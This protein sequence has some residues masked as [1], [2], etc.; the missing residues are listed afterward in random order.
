MTGGGRQGI[1][2]TR[3]SLLN[4]L[5]RSH[6][7]YLFAEV[8]ASCVRHVARVLRHGPSADRNSEA[9][10]LFSEVMAKLVGAMSGADDAV[11]DYVGRDV[12]EPWTSHDDPKRDGRVAWLIREIGGQKSLAH[13]YEDVRRRQHGGK[14]RRDGYRHVQLEEEHIENLAVEPDDPHH[15]TDVRRAWLG[16]LALAQAEFRPD[17][18]VSVLLDVMACDPEVQA[19]FGAEWPISKIIA[20]LNVRHPARPWNDDRVDNAKKR[21]KNWIARLMRDN[22]LDAVDLMGLLAR[23]GRSLEP[24]KPASSAI[25]LEPS[26]RRV[27]AARE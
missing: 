14:W 26:V 22:G 6:Q 24:E 27:T 3:L 4:S 5:P 8:R 20:A 15:E 25:A 1:A 9:L 13:R 21:L 10:E 23:R 11:G 18:D 12:G 16:L 2:A 19:G 7:V 17:E